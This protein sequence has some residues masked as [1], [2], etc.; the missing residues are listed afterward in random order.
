MTT[1]PLYQ[2]DT[3]WTGLPLGD[4]PSTIGKKGCLLV[5]LTMAARETGVRPS[6]LPPHANLFC[7]E[8]GAFEG[9]ALIIHKAAAALDLEAP[10]FERVVA[11]IGSGALIDAVSNALTAGDLA[12]LHVDHEGDDDGDH[13]ILAYAIKGDRVLCYDP[14]VGRVSLTWPGLESAGEVVWGPKDF[15][16]YRVTAVRPIRKATN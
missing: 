1:G 3:H 10:L 11:P 16:R 9:D 13:F 4:G 8:A 15:R 14:A 2:S 7:L 5:A 6:L 12:I